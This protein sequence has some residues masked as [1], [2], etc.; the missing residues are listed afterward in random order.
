MIDLAQAGS[1]SGDTRWLKERPEPIPGD[2]CAALAPATHTMVELPYHI[3]G[4][5]RYLVT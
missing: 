4:S 5:S 3:P 1:G 2:L